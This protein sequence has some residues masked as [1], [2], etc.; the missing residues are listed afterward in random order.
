MDSAS[1]RSAVLAWGLFAVAALIP[2]DLAAGQT[3]DAPQPDAQ[4]GQPA[5][6]D[7]QGA[8]GA[9]ASTQD[10]AAAKPADE[11]KPPA[12]LRSVADLTQLARYRAAKRRP[13]IES[14]LEPFLANL[15][16]DPKQNAEFLADQYVEIANLGEGVVPLLLERLKPRTPSPADANTAENAQRVLARFDVDDFLE[17]VLELVENDRELGRM[18][19]LRLI[20]GSRR[21]HTVDVLLQVFDELNPL[22]LREAIVAARSIGSPR[23]AAAAA[24]HLSSKDPQLK[25]LVLQYLTTVRAAVVVPDIRAMLGDSQVPNSLKTEALEFLCE[26][27]TE[28]DVATA[29]AMLPMLQE[30]GVR[31]EVRVRVAEALARI[32]PE[33]DEKTVEALAALIPAD[34]HELA[35][36]S[37]KTRE[38]LGDRRARRQLFTELEGLIRQDQTA[39]NYARRGDAWFAFE[40]WGKAAD[41]YE[42]AARASSIGSDKYYL[43]MAASYARAGRGSQALA[44]LRR[45]DE[46]QPDL[47]RDSAIATDPALAEVIR[48]DAGERFLRGLR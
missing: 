13:A 41:D 45:I 15:A 2:Q 9:G 42:R 20:G 19:A 24:K 33:E 35:I 3:P 17:P 12:Q 40:E 39:A 1:L 29:H 5:K 25:R 10:P 7:G 46:M 48:S 22:E 30:T 37:A 18:L 21:P 32:A 8:G 44:S 27:V 11:P 36:A 31:Y 16:L 28:T 6:D 23:L 47:L 4:P 14:K 38:V 34:L 43:R 26:T